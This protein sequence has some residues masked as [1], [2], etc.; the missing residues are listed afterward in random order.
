MIDLIKNKNKLLNDNI[1]DIKDV[2]LKKEELL[3]HAIQLAQNHK[4]EKRQRSTKMLA[5]R[6][7]KSYEGIFR[8]YKE[9]NSITNNGGDLSPASEWLLDNF[10]K[11]EEQVKDVRQSLSTDRFVKLPSLMGG[12]LKGY[13]R[14]YAIALELVSHTDGRVEEDLLIDFLK[15]Y[16]SIQILSLSETWSLSLMI[17]IALIENIRIICGDIYNTQYH[18]ALAENT[19]KLDKE[20]MFENINNNIDENF[21]ISYIEHILARIRR[22]GQNLPDILD[23]IELKLEEYNTSI[24]DIIKNEHKKHAIRRISIGNSITGLHEISTL[25]WNDIFEAISIVEE[26]LRKDP[27]KVYSNMDF[28]SRD[29]YRKTIEKISKQWKVPEVRIANQAVK[30]ALEADSERRDSKKNHVGY[31]LV[32]KGRIKLFEKLKLGKDYL[33]L[34]STALYIMPILILAILITYFIINTFL[35]N[36][37]WVKLLLI[38]PFLF[39]S[40]SDISV[41]FINYLFMKAYPVSLLP[42][43][44]FKEGIPKEAMTM[45][46]MPAL[47]TDKKSAKEL[48]EKME[49]YYLAN[50][51]K[52]IFFALVGDF[53]DSN[54]EKEKKDE[55]IV[56]EAL[57]GVKI[58][59]DVYSKE[60]ERFYYFHRKRIF[61]KI[62]NKWM[63]WERK[64]GAIIEFN[65]MIRG[66]DNTFHIKTG[67]I[68]KL[69]DLKYIITIDSDTNLKMNSAKKLIGIIAHPLNRAVYDEDKGIIVD[70]YGIIQPRI[71]L[72]IEDA[73]RTGFARVFSYSVGIDPYST[74]VSDIYQDVFGEGIFTGKGIYDLDYF[75]KVMEGKIEENTILSHDLL[76][77][78]LMRTGLAT[79]IELI[80]GY[81]TKYKSYIM[82]LHRWVRGDWQLIKWL[83]S[84]KYLSSLSKWKVL[85]N[86]RRSFIAPSLFIFMLI[87][88]IIPETNVYISIGI[89]LFILY[90][91]NLLC[92]PNLLMSKK[93]YLVECILILKKGLYQL[94]IQFAFLPYNAYMMIDAIVRTL[95]RVFVS[96][97]HLL[98]WVTAAEVERKLGDSIKDYVVRMKTS[99]ALT[100]LFFILIL[101]Y[102]QANLICFLPPIFL[103]LL[104]PYIA[105]KISKSDDKAEKE[106][107]KFNL[108]ILKRISRKTWAYFE[109]F[110]REEYNYLPPDNF[111]EYPFKGVALRTSPTNIGLYLVSLLSARD[112]GYITT[113]QFAVNTEK[114]LK[115]IEKME[116]WRGHLFNWYDIKTLEV[117]RPQYVSTVDSG[118]FVTYLLLL[119]QGLSEYLNKPIIDEKV[120]NG[121]H[122]TTMIYNQDSE[123]LEILFEKLKNSKAPQMI[124]ILNAIKELSENKNECYES[125]EKVL[126]FIESINN[127]IK[128]YY[129]SI[130]IIER[131]TRLISDDKSYSK[132]QKYLEELLYNPSLLSLNK[133]YREILE[134]LSFTK[135]LIFNDNKENQ[136][137]LKLKEELEKVSANTCSLIRQI[138]DLIY[139][140]DNIIENME[141]NHLYDSKRNLFSIGFDVEKER[142]TNS[143]YDLLAS[144]ARIASYW[145]I[146]KGHVPLKHWYK[147]GRSL[148]KIDGSRALV[149]WSGTMFEY[150]MPALILKNYK[151]TLLNETYNAVVK[152]QKLYGSRLSIPWGISESGFFSFDFNLNYQYKAFGIPDLGLKRGLIEDIVIS[153]YSTFLALKEDSDGSIENIRRLVSYEMEAGYGLY[154]SLDF[155]PN[156]LRKGKKKEVVKSFMAHHL[157][158]SIL[159]LNNFLNKDVMIHR[160]HSHPIIKAGE[161]MLQERIPIKSI[162]TKEYKEWL[163]EKGSL[164]KDYVEPVRSYE[165]PDFVPPPCHLL[166]NGTYSLLINT[167][168]GGYSKFND[169]MINRWRNDYLEREYGSFIFIK[170]MKSGKVWS[171]SHKI[172]DTEPD[173]YRVSFLPSGAEFMRKDD[174]VNSIMEIFISPEDNVEIRRLKIENHSIED[175]IFEITSYFELSLSSMESDI[176]HRVFCN[177][178]IRTD[179]LPEYESIVATRRPREHREGEKHS[180]HSAIYEGETIGPTQYETSRENFIGRGH[181]IHNPVL[182]DQPLTNTI[183]IVLDP[184][185]SIRKRIKVSAGNTAT[186][187]FVTGY[188]STESELKDLCGKYNEISSIR[189][190]YELSITRSQVE[191]AYLSLSSKEILSFDNM[192][193]HLI[194]KSPSKRQYEDLIKRNKKS[195]TSLWAYGISGDFPIIL[196]TVKQE[197]DIQAIKQGLKAFEYLNIKGLKV[198]LVILNEDESGYLQPLRTMI[199]DIV[200]KSSGRYLASK[201][202]GIFIRDLSNM[203]YDDVLLLYASAGIILKGGEGPFRKQL[204]TIKQEFPSDK[205]PKGMENIHKVVDPIENNLIFFNGYGGFSPVGNEYIIKLD[206]DVNT[207]APWINIISNIDLGFMISESGA[208]STWSENSRENK[209]TPWSNDP[210]IDDIGEII[211]LKDLDKGNVW[212][213]T[214]KPIK[215][216]VMCK[217]RHGW[218]YSI[219]EKDYLDIEHEMTVFVPIKDRVKISLIKLRNKSSKRRKLQ[220]TY[221]VEPVLGVHEYYTKQNIITEFDKNNNIFLIKNFFNSEFHNR[222]T[223][224]F[225]TENIDS[226]S[227]DKVGFLGINSDKG[228]PLGLLNEKLNSNTGA[229]YEPCGIIRIIVDIEANEE[230]EI[231]FFLGQVF[232]EGTLL[233]YIIRYYRLNYTKMQLNKAKKFWYD[234]VLNTIKVN[235]PDSTMNLLLN[236]WLVYQVIS[237][238]LWGRS[239]FYQSG[240]AFG[241]R[242][243]LQDATNI[244]LILPQLLK[245]QILLHSQHQF[246]E[247]DVQHWWHPLECCKGVRTRFT[248]DLLWLPYAVI[249]YTEITGDFSILKME[250]TFLEDNILKDGED[251]RYGTPNVST[252][253]GTIYEHCN[254]AIEKSLKFGSHGLPLM[255]SG[256]WNDGMNM[257]GNKGKGESVWLGFF[258]YDILKGYT[259]LCA[260]MNDKERE[261]RYNNEA[262]RLKINIEENGWDGNWYKRAFF[263]DGTPL[264]SSE[265]SECAIDSIVQSWAVL[266][267][268][269][270]YTRCIKAM[271]SLKNYLI[272]EDAGIILLFTPPFDKGDKNPGYIKSYVPGVRENGGQYTHAASWVICAFAS[273]GQ[274]NTAWK[275]FNMI[276]PINHTRTLKECSIYKT[277]PYVMSADVYSVNPHAG[278]GGWSW[279][280]GA[281]GW[282]YKAGL[283]YILGFRKRQDMLYINPCIP[284]HWERFNIEYRYGSAKYN[285]N[286]T[287]PE[288]LNKGVKSITV[289]GVNQKDGI[290]LI[291]DNN[292]HE[293]L[294]VMG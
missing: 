34:D 3:N 218:G 151:G 7:D 53:V 113:S 44:E 38:A 123:I 215:S 221:Y 68:S 175:I 192:I 268:A 122:D 236:G 47:L 1:Y 116:S 187:S 41:H 220:L 126:Q 197:Q 8:I 259:K 202:K 109:D 71:G 11:I 251:E 194:Y 253:K 37:E 275:L 233:D 147:L 227:G 33:R 27:S 14:V 29:Y 61:N 25:N 107:G 20:L 35:K 292:I 157:G 57:S 270:D 60:G 117:L 261:I 39:I 118:N 249:E 136:Y 244:G 97:K 247:G 13:P 139:R 195:Q 128:K 235:T 88:S 93:K 119:R 76:E 214:K 58:L 217:I 10:Y 115:V 146:V 145:A 158:M 164:G 177:L 6:M 5:G 266:S 293:I 248:D 140:I 238:R 155:T 82:R 49:V 258:L 278:R 180:F 89:P 22:E 170:N 200:E 102:N 230:K 198:D 83:F 232:D 250:E 255:G 15:T 23:Y 149:S 245:N 156:R 86:L 185:M 260:L 36:I 294:V 96:K 74:A 166:S 231:A 64:R 120:I 204:K 171:A 243:Q 159:A 78:S 98:E 90:F 276:N 207:P 286:V 242:D 135:A 16:Q 56:N 51:D 70:G 31:Y 101:I 226:Y 59:N 254:R 95:S 110:V 67:D 148:T 283:E 80:D 100:I 142:I 290:K 134:N 137:F 4:V 66:K 52:N 277:E 186:V 209:L 188:G 216:E 273:L 183:G 219:F 203:H 92:L 189:R 279:Y 124:C 26:K 190:A 241:F 228:F 225:S 181:D 143:Y 125:Q 19:L 263:D 85:D 256:D 262:D 114:T 237:C 65:N 18:W 45:V 257:V 208:G 162:I 222:V 79:D 239:G 211:Y 43:L 32:D 131:I 129:L 161:F 212:T 105:Y 69:K 133:I 184:C 72:N 108:K 2:L 144:E 154:E 141:F 289:D 42:R 172:L 196:I 213:I 168:G 201:D 165:S 246:K 132:L 84:K 174:D 73:N 138:E 160:F 111:Q 121:L 12:H 182:L 77:G 267:E 63:G 269:A 17:R 81:P 281:A 178:F 179:F 24:N 94:I 163:E 150:F 284:N 152:S 9:L 274:G 288:G 199:N 40:I 240:G 167:R 91:P 265:N 285:I 55:S 75:N 54:K 169:V 103:W 229:S 191:S 106:I 176:A 153:S 206:V 264:G 287:N 252:E 234:E 62:Q 48:I 87:V 223:F 280:T 50:K 291:D 104:S 271:D 224:M 282:Y 127:D 210:I 272:K 30:L 99:Y 46:I 21:D 193:S 28:E 205:K 130:D 112:F 173:G